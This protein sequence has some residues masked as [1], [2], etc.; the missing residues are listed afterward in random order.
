[1]PRPLG[2]TLH[3]SLP[4]KL[5]HFEYCVM[6]PGE[7]GHL[8]VLILKDDHSGY[9][10]FEPKEE[11]E[12]ETTDNKLIRWFS[13]FGPVRSSISERGSHFKLELLKTLRKYVFASHHYILAYCPWSNGSV[14]LLRAT[15]AI[16]SELQQN[17]STVILMVQYGL[18]NSSLER[19][20]NRTP[21][22]VFTSLS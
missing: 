8:Y 22:S 11:A 9:V 16:L 18:N 13:T 15:R 2:H 20:G 14:E 5:L 3:A 17:Q 10:W 21:Q 7:G 12:A 1:M 6:S 19:L 4:N